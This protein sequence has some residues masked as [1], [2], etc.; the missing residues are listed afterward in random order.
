MDAV[1][2]TLGNRW[3]AFFGPPERR[4]FGCHHPPRDGLKHELA[5]VLCY[6]LGLEY[7]YSHRA[8]LHLASRLAGQGF[9][10]GRFDYFG[11]GDSAGDDDD[12]S[13]SGWIGDISIAIEETRRAMQRRHIALIGLRLGASLALQ[14]AVQRGD[15]LHLVLW[16]P[17]VDGREYFEQIKIQHQERLWGH[18]FDRPTIEQ[19]NE[20][21]AELLGLKMNDRLIDEI[22]DLNLLAI[23]TRPARSVLVFDSRG[24]G[25]AERLG[26]HLRSLEVDVV[27]EHIPGFGIWTEDPDKGL[28]PHQALQAIVN[29]MS[30]QS[31]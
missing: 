25:S 26:D 15:V 31:Q 12:A 18:F 14:S 11:T 30:S 22:T 6:P 10:V 20:R 16:D 21:P 1:R 2:F 13:L 5:A 8:F 7:A 27:Y 17:I 4:L 9:D 29:W 24:D 3:P 28:V 23:D 19:A